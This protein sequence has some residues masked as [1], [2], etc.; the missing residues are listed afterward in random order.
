MS[1]LQPAFPDPAGPASDGSDLP[2]QAPAPGYS[3]PERRRTPRRTAVAWPTPAPQ[4][5]PAFSPPPA[6]PTPAPTAAAVHAAPVVVPE[7][8][9]PTAAMPRFVPPAPAAPAPAPA[10]QAPA[11][12]PQVPP[13]F[14]TRL[15]PP[16]PPQAPA[17]PVPPQPPAAPAPPSTPISLAGADIPAAL[18]APVAPQPPAA[19]VPP[20]APAPLPPAPAAD[21]RSLAPPG[22]SGERIR[23]AESAQLLALDPSFPD[24][25]DGP[26]EPPQLLTTAT[27]TATTAAVLPEPADVAALA[28]PTAAAASAAVAAG[29]DAPAL[30]REVG[31]S[32]LAGG[33]LAALPRRGDGRAFGR[34]RGSTARIAGTLLVLSLAVAF[35]GPPIANALRD[36]PIIGDALDQLRALALYPRVYGLYWVTATL[37]VLS[38]YGIVAAHME[39]QAE[40][41]GMRQDPTRRLNI[42][43]A[44]LLAIT[45]S[46]GLMS[47]LHSRGWAAG[48]ASTGFFLALSLLVPLGR[49]PGKRAMDSQPERAWLLL[50]LVAI[51]AMVLAPSIPT[52]LLL[53]LSF[54]RVRTGWSEITGAADHH[55]DG[56]VDQTNR[57]S[58][59]IITV[60]VLV[61]A[62]LGL[63]AMHQ[64]SAELR[65]LQSERGVST[66]PG[67]VQGPTVDHLER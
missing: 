55:A 13:A 17:A 39:Q 22:F 37:G 46:A 21:H 12:A 8:A 65:T 52:I 25:W 60:G 10:A 7:P 42:A 58:A 20:A 61:A 28:D 44:S 14:A 11:P 26:A 38:G 35:V 3:G 5:A 43:L 32:R 9:A 18:S 16:A 63:H 15:V 51:P 59:L 4:A 47:L 33:M 27:A 62:S 54:T 36:V 2:Q 34:D 31:G 29:A 67:A 64:S 57:A 50:F 56:P 19:P 30:P 48:A 45:G 66:V 49:M 53:L 40:K 24:D 6:A 1:A 23:A 41:Q